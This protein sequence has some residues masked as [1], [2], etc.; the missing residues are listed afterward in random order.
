MNV[1]LSKYLRDGGTNGKVIVAQ[2]LAFE[3]T[4]FNIR[5]IAL[6]SLFPE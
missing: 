6:Q 3:V 1:V 2:E 4:G 5:L